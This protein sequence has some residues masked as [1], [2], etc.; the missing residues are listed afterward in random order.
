[1]NLYIQFKEAYDE[2]LKE[3]K[4]AQPKQQWIAWELFQKGV[5]IGRKQM[6]DE[7]QYN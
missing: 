4:D 1:M 2:T 5:Q 7:K 6:E 3:L